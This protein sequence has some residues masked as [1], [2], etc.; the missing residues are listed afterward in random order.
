MSTDVIVLYHFQRCPYCEK[1]RRAFRFFNLRYESREIDP[2]DRAEVQRVSG[3]ES[4]PLILDGA[5]VLHGSTRI[6]E[7]LDREYGGAD[8]L[9]PVDG[10][11]SSASYLMDRYAES[12]W[13]KLT[14]R[15][16]KQKGKHGRPLDKSGVASL[17]Q[18]INGESALLDN[19]FRFHR[20]AA[21][22][23]LSLGDLSLSAFLSRIQEF[24]DFTIHTQ[25]EYLLE[26]YDRVN[27][28]LIRE[29]KQPSKL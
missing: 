19:Y 6:I 1:V 3:Q 12:V 8:H 29:E 7:Y 14:S 5:T 27:K 18:K 4:V 24:S 13:G 16:L 15:A 26:W 28:R 11:E 21:G 20:F 10:W 2:T 22:D 23:S 9:I 25:F 17:Q